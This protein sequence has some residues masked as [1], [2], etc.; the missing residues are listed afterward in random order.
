VNTY[1]LSTGEAAVRLHMSPDSVRRRVISGQLHGIR[2]GK[3]W[4][5]TLESIRQYEDALWAKTRR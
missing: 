2:M 3:L 4:R 1:S 5:V